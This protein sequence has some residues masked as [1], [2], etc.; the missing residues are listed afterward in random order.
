MSLRPSSCTTTLGRSHH[1]VDAVLRAHHADVGGQVTAAAAQLGL[2]RAA[3]Q[4]VRVGAG[5]D[6]GDVS[7]RLAAAGDRDLP[8]GVVRGDHV[9][10]GAVGAPLERAQPPVGQPRAVRRSGTR[11]AR[12]TGRGGRTRTWC[13]PERGAPGRSAR[14][15]PADCRPA[16]RRTGRTAAA[17]QGQP[18]GGQ[19]RV[20]VLGDE[21]ELA[22][23]RRVRPVLVQLDAV[24]DLVG[25]VAVALRADDADLVASRD[26]C[27]ALEPD[28]PVE[29]HRQVLDD[30]Q[31]AAHQPSPS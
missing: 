30:D 11:T 26:E 12:G 20:H 10:R 14:R 17:L 1:D 21:A 16:A 6:D 31:D 28:P 4:P 19:E 18:R 27:L 29:R 22:A 7:G 15:C 8:V 3:L 23:A 9:V 24:D 5:P 13:G 25:R 2:R